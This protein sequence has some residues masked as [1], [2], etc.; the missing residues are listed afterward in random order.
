MPKA[1]KTEEKKPEEQEKKEVK[2]D[3]APQI[4]RAIISQLGRP[5]NLHEVKIISLWD[6]RYRIN[7][8]CGDDRGPLHSSIRISDSF[9]VKVSPEGGIISCD[10]PLKKKYTSE[11]PLALPPEKPT[12]VADI[13]KP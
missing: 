8:W 6:D 9:F 10:P 12:N 2:V 3:L 7:V 1:I 4:A 11:K 5:K 13:L